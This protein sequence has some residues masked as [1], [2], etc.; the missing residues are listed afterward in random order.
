VQNFAHKHLLKI[1]ATTFSDRGEAAITEKWR[2]RRKNP[3]PHS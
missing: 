2:R 1:E 3:K